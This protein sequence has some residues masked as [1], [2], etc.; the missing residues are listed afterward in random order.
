MA[1]SL[2]A[3]ARSRIVFLY[4]DIQSTS[5]KKNRDI[6]S[7]LGNKHGFFARETGRRCVCVHV[8]VCVCVCVCVNDFDFIVL[9]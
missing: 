7:T 2:T 9:L 3:A 5:G 6:Q 4:R 1:S 8:C